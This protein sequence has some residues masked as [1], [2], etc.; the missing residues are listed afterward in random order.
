M[1]R[2]TSYSYWIKELILLFILVISFSC[3]K[4]NDPSVISPKSY[5]PAYPGSYWVYT[6][7]ETR[8]VEPDYCLHSYQQGVVGPDFSEEAYVPKMG[9]QYVYEYGITQ[10]SVT[11]PL[12]QLLSEKLN[13]TWVVKDWNNEEIIRKVIAINDT[14]KINQYPSTSNKINSYNPVIV[15]IEY[16]SSEG[17]KHWRSKEYY[18]KNIGLIRRDINISR[19]II[20]PVIVFELVSCSINHV[21]D[22]E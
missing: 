6:D 12:K 9:Q 13:D 1:K 22:D 4:E 3:Q 11:H 21:F 2:K 16:S 10:N 17:E 8:T 7:G 19:E 20:E 5:F 18:A 14:V 15:V